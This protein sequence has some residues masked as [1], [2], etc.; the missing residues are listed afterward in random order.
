MWA[1][2]DFVVT[3]NVISVCIFRNCL[4]TSILNHLISILG[5]ITLAAFS[6]TAVSEPTMHGMVA[7]LTLAVF[8]QPIAVVS[9]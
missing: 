4:C 2:Q 8:K 3:K 1:L 7:T 9:S 6:L 5:P